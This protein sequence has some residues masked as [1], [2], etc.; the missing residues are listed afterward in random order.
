MPSRLKAKSAIPVDTVDLGDGDSVK[1]YRWLTAA[2]REKV[3][4][5]AV[6]ISP[7]GQ[8]HVDTSFVNR[9]TLMEAIVGWEGPGFCVQDHEDSRDHHEGENGCHPVEVTMAMLSIL[10]DGDF[11]T[12]LNKLA[13]DNPTAVPPGSPFSPK[14]TTAT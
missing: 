4:A 10:P 6:S 13:E 7:K 1:M 2:D 14:E 8:P 12:L 3:N 9:L 11:N 5:T